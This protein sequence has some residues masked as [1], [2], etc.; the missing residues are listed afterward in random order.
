MGDINLTPPQ[1]LKRQK[2]Q[3]VVGAATKASLVF[4]LLSVLLSAYYFFVTF[5]LKNNLRDLDLQNKQ[6]AQEISSLQDIENYAKGISGKYLILQRYLESRLKYSA[7]FKELLGRKPVGVEIEKVDFDGVGKVSRLYGVSTNE[8]LISLFMSNLE[9][10]GNL[11][12]DSGI[13]L[14]GKK[15]FTDVNLDSLSLDET[16]QARFVISFYLNEEAFLR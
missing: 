13:S 1:E 2:T 8:V 7:V 4:L 14:E 5:K 9:K 6:I 11:S 3:Y 16:K 12:L 10:I 15:A